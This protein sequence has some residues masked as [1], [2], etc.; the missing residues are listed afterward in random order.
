V[1]EEA[2][3]DAGLTL[4][5]VFA[6]AAEGLE[7]VAAAGG[8]WS[9]GATTFATVDGNAAEFRL[10]PV[11][12]AAARRTPDTQASDHGPDWVRFEPVEL[13]DQAIDRAEA[14]FGSAHRRA[15]HEA[16]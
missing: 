13:D 2:G 14:W 7:G 9:V 5:D 4:A 8:T 11:V 6:D 16:R 12:A 10:D 1:T 15:L 3:G